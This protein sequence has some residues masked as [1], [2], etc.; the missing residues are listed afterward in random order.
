MKL[1]F[2]CTRIPYI[3]HAAPIWHALPQEFRGAFITAPELIAYARSLDIPANGNE[4]SCLTNAA[5]ILSRAELKKLA[6]RHVVFMEHGVGASYN[7]ETHLPRNILIELILTTPAQFGAHRAVY[8]DRVVVIGCPK[9]DKR[10]KHRRGEIPVIVFS[11]H[12]EQRAF[13]ETRSAWPW[14]ADALVA[15]AANKKYK[16]IG[17]KHPGDKR[18]IEGWCVENGI[19][20]I[21]DFKDVIKRADL[22]IADNT[23]TLYEFAATDRPVVCLS[24]PWYRRTVEHGMRFW[25]FEPGVDCSHPSHLAACVEDALADRPERRALRQRAVQAAYGELD[26]EAT[27]RA[28]SAIQEYLV[29]GPAALPERMASLRRSRNSAPS[30]QKL[31]AIVR[32]SKSVT[33]NDVHYPEGAKITA[34][35]ARCMK[36][37]GILSD[38]R[39]G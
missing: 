37:A 2:V 23:S 19:E 26:G 25:E 27:E 33:Y 1:D 16:V 11:H 6:H 12:W 32:L 13:P 21:A 15:L 29:N 9:L 10:V 24:P 4:G 17:H 34:E 20:F 22:Y 28:V 39:L 36:Q 8:G 3:D 31:P 14:D 18:D 38:A 35:L 30:R 5:L 7:G